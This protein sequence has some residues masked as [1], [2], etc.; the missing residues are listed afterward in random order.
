MKLGEALTRRAAQAQRL[1]DLRS[2]INSNVLV[3]EGDKPSEDPDGLIVE[4]DKLSEEHANLV[5]RIIKTNTLT[6]VNG[7]SNIT[8]LTLLMARD[9]LARTKNTLLEAANNA[10]LDRNSFMYSRSEIKQE[11]VIDIENTRKKADEVIEA[12]RQLDI[13]LQAINWQTDLLD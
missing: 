9:H 1:A 12:G 2:R 8:I 11:P 6:S 3:Q 5:Q 7:D 10:T 4:Y 13:D